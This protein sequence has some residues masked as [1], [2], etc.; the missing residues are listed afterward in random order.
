MN[1]AFIHQH[2]AG[3][4]PRAEPMRYTYDNQPKPGATGHHIDRPA[5][6]LTLERIHH[7]FYAC[8]FTGSGW[9]EFNLQ[10]FVQE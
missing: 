10:D 8:F 1:P 7:H 2:A 9:I 5:E 6:R 3:F 4:V